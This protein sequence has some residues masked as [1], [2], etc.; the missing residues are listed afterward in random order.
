MQVA[1]NAQSIFERDVSSAEVAQQR[2]KITLAQIHLCEVCTIPGGFEQPD[3]LLNE[4]LLPLTQ[5][6]R[7]AQP[8]LP[9]EDVDV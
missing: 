8:L 9:Q 4:F 2:E 5:P 7:L 3:Q 6:E 1:P